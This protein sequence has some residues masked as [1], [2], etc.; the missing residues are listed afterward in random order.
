[1]AQLR[2]ASPRAEGELFRRSMRRTS[3]TR[4]W[5]DGRNRGW[6]VPEDSAAIGGVYGSTV[7]SSISLK[8]ASLYF[9]R[10]LFFASPRSV[11][12]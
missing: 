12:G 6:M 4:G 1:M 5:L 3:S 8:L 11:G 9:R 7:A 10:F 2:S